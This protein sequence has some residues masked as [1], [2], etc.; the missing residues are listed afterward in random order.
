MQKQE[1]ERTAKQKQTTTKI[2]NIPKSGDKKRHKKE[3]TTAIEMEDDSED[4]NK[5]TK[6]IHKRGNQQATQL[7][8]GHNKVRRDQRQSIYDKDAEQ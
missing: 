2:E 3:T 7:N 5:Q 1:N 4:D 8:R 6:A